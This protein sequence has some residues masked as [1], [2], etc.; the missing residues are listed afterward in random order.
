MLGLASEA[1][2]LARGQRA[3]GQDL[4]PL[5]GALPVSAPLR[6]ALE[7]ARGGGARRG[8]RGGGEGPGVRGRDVQGVRPARARRRRDAA[9]G[10]RRVRAVQAGPPEGAGGGPQGHRALPGPL[11]PHVPPPV[12]RPPCSLRA[13]RCRGLHP[14]PAPEPIR[15]HLPLRVDLRLGHL[16]DGGAPEAAALCL[17]PGRRRAPGGGHPTGLQ[18][19]DPLRHTQGVA[20]PCCGRLVKAARHGRLAHTAGSVCLGRAG[21]RGPRGAREGADGGVRVAADEPPQP[22]VRPQRARHAAGDV[23]HA[24]PGERRGAVGAGRAA[25][26]H[27][28][29]RAGGGHGGPPR[30]PGRRGDA[31]GPAGA[32]PS[33][34]APLLLLRSP[35]VRRR[36]GPLQPLWCRS[37]AR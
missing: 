33:A 1:Q 2:P 6:L 25:A 36:V 19:L 29:G 4:P 11:P 16:P 26:R 34:C 22:G 17:R 8:R 18:H 35:L 37:R 5:L 13:D 21:A 15:G 30:P 10:A 12:L 20:R 14:G 32:V 9:G 24:P 27:A 31:A 23:E 3:L 28:H 7:P